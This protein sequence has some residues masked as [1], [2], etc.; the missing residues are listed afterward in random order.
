MCMS[1][2]ATYLT[3]SALTRYIKRK[4]DA[5]PYLR[6]V[7][8]KGELS[9]VKYHSNGHIYFT[10]KDSGA[11]IACAMFASQAKALSFRAEEGMNVFVTGDISVY[12]N[13]G[14]YQFYAKTMEPDGVGALFVAYEQ[15]KR[16][17]ETEGLFSQALKQP[18]PVIPLHIGVI[19]SST[20]AAI[21]DILTTL[22]RRFPLAKVT[23]APTLVQGP[24]AAPAIVKAIERM[25][26][27]PDVDVLIVGR[28][29]GSIED[30]WA[31]NEETVARAIVKSRVPIISAVGH[32]TDTTIADFVADLR[33][34]TPTAAAELAVPDQLQ[35][36]KSLRSFSDRVTQQTLGKVK[37]SRIDLQRVNQSTVFQDASRLYRPFVEQHLRMT[38]QLQQATMRSIE[39]AGQQQERL[40]L[41]L[42]HVSPIDR[43]LRANQQLE[44]IRQR[45]LYSTQ[46]QT[47]AKKHQLVNRIRT[48]EALSPLQTLQ[49][50]FLYAEKEHRVVKTI[51][52]IQQEDTLQLHFYD[53]TATVQV[54]S[55]EKGGNHGT[56]I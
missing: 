44:T 55:L 34:P 37:Q 45:I 22:E 46:Q 15:L 14:N 30:L 39:R 54:Q 35:L 3:V 25:N 40:G 8:V 29:G 52:E 17:L 53:G 49:K 21:R 28:G 32:E 19:T 43:I 12:E 26:Q 50:G 27:F 11:R 33:A 5:D 2:A 9:N 20:G 1:S 36:L 18:L 23:V 31:F 41:R 6:K 10:L 47:T 16:K 38:E 13:A 48:L 24:G 51:D 56:D 7:Y 42:M 4:F